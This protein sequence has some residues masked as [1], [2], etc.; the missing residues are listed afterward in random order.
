MCGHFFSPLSRLDL[1]IIFLSS[2]ST[3]DWKSEFLKKGKKNKCFFTQNLTATFK[4][5]VVNYGTINS[6]FRDCTKEENL[7]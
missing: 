5:F 6:S 3:I 4:I 2:H 7:N 1:M